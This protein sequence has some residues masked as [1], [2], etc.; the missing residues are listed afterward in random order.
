MRMSDTSSLPITLRQES[1]G[2]I[3]FDPFDGAL[4]EVD[5]DAYRAVLDFT[6]SDPP[7]TDPQPQALLKKLR[8]ELYDFDNRA[9]RLI[10]PVTPVSADIP[11]LSAPTLVDFQIT[12]QCFEGCRHCYAESTAAGKHG[13][14]EDIALALDQIAE[15]GVLQIAL[16]GG[17][18]LLHP[19]IGWILQRCFELGIVPNLTTSGRSIDDHKLD[20]LEYYC[21]AV[22]LSLEGVGDGF[23]RFRKS[24]FR[25]FD[26]LLAL[27]L[28]SD[29][30]TV[31]QITLTA[32]TLNA[33]DEIVDYCLARP[34]LYGVIFLAFKP[35]GRGAQFGTPLAELPHSIV[36][37]QLMRAFERL[38]GHCRVGFD[39][40][41]TPAVTGT[42]SG[43]DE[44]AAQYLEGCSAL[45]TSI[46]LSH[47]LDVMPCTFTAKHKVGN[48]RQKHLAQIWRDL[49]THEFRT[50]MAKIR[51]KSQHCADC[52]KYS[53]C[54]GGCPVMPLVDCARAYLSGDELDS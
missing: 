11:V 48:L 51:T 36:H 17:E 52:G 2:G 1:F 27:I 19:E 6:R 16:G 24:G 42:G 30:P 13:L 9:F 7:W 31:L 26:R 37:A 12:N 33:L 8:E 38:T 45:R 23:A 5:H 29:I 21:G 40:C 32:E 43:F 49:T 44:H 46:G 3:L 20:L 25:D 39:C 50:T 53:Y 14:I 15:V 10:A 28:E 34:G 54:L 47:T 35:V 4:V 22:G 18:P 41:L